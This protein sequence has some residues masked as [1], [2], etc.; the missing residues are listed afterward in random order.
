MKNV[1]KLWIALGALVLLTPLGLLASGTAW[2]EWGSDEL[3]TMLGYVPA[4]M[5]RFS[6]LWHA[7]LP[8]YTIPGLGDTPGYVLSAVVGI[9]LIALVTYG[10]GKLLASGER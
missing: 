8:D 4:G 2:G 10:L 5:A 9:A 3:S 7:P 6:E 1:K